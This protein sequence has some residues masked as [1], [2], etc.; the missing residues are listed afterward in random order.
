[1]RVPLWL[2][3]V[4][5]AVLAAI[6]YGIELRVALSKPLSLSGFP[7]VLL[8]LSFDAGTAVIA[9]ELLRAAFGNLAWFTPTWQV[10]I[11]ALTG[12]ALLRSQLAVIG[13][14]QE[15]AYYGPASS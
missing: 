4:A 10:I 3:D 11:A 2:V 14:G 5:A 9:C 1:M 6:F 15:D 8:R 7:W 13:S 12:P